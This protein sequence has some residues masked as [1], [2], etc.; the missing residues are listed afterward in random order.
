MNGDV[1]S[2]QVLQQ[3]AELMLLVLHLD[4]LVQNKFLTSFLF[5][6]PLDLL[7]SSELFKS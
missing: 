5:L 3:F 4:L 6:P 2:V 7:H 1:A